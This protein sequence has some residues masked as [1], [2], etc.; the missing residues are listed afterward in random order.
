MFHD[1]ID[2]KPESVEQAA[3]EKEYR[4]GRL[5]PF[6]HMHVINYQPK[7]GKTLQQVHPFYSVAF[8]HDICYALLNHSFVD[9]IL[10]L[11]KSL[12]SRRGIVSLLHDVDATSTTVVNPNLKPNPFAMDSVSSL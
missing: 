3:K 4:N 7:N 11:G 9:A 12:V 1:E 8:R 5:H 6:E 10:S 2:A